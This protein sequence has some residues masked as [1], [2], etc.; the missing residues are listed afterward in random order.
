MGH[1]FEKK[2]PVCGRPPGEKLMPFCSQRCAD[3]D[4]GAWLGEKYRVPTDDTPDARLPGDS[5]EE[6]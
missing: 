5:D 6:V 2:C 3:I 4:L 1:A